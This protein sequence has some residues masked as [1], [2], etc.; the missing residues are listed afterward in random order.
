[1]NVSW[2]D[3]KLGIRMLARYPWLSAVSV[4]GMALAIAIGAGYVSIVDLALDSTLPVSGGDRIVSI[5][6]RAVDGPD[7]GRKERLSPQDFVQWRDGVTSLDELG[8]FRDETRN[9]MMADGRTDVVKVAAITASGFRLMHATALI[10]RTLLDEDERP[11]AAAVLVVGYDPWQRELNGDPRVV[12]TSV[13]LDGMAHTI[14]GVM[15]EGF[16]FP[17]RH[18]YWT[19][20]TI[21]TGGTIDEPRLLGF[22]RIADGFSLERVRA[23]LAAVGE[24]VSRASPQHRANVRLEPTPYTQTFTGI[25]GPQEILALRAFQLGAGLL[26]LIVA[27]N[28]AIL[29]YART[30]T[31]T[32]EVVVRTALGASRHRILLQFFVEAL[33]LTLA[34]AAVGLG[35]VAVVFERLRV[36]MRQA[37]HLDQIPYWFQPALSAWAVFYVVLLAVIAAVVVGVVPALKTTGRAVY[38][39]LQQFSARGSGMRLGRVWTTLIVVQVVSAV[40][41]LPIAMYNAQQVLALAT[42]TPAAAAKDMLRSTVLIAR[43]GTSSDAPESRADDATRLLQRIAAEPEVA[44]VTF[45]RNVPGREPYAT[46]D[47]E[48]T[49]QIVA[50]STAVATN[51]FDVFG[52]PILAGRGFVAADA[53][54]GAT[55]IVVDRAFADR[56]GAGANVVGRRIRY[57]NR[58]SN[59]NIELGRPLDIVGVV[60]VFATSFAAPPPFVSQPPRFYHAAAPDQIDGSTLIVRTKSND[61][62]Q[63]AQRLRLIAASV[64]PALK[65]QELVSVADAWDYD[66]HAPWIA[67]FVILGVTGSVLLLSGAGIYSMMS[68]AVAARRREIGIRVALGANARHV[69]SGIFG[70][71]IAQLGSGVAIGLSVA[72]G[73]EWASGGA[74]MNGHGVVLLPVVAGLMLIVGLLAALGPARHGLAIPPTE[75]LRAE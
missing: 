48:Q 6:S 3:V 53:R 65:L 36:W 31:R 64:D 75:A 11:G 57:L 45:A 32:G 13:R 16:L 37:P 46:V 50:S 26:L 34:S 9:L 1:M 18:Q 73:L 58:A 38:A 71:A 55:A 35:I 27:V 22:G 29:I 63:F 8:A 33:V 30:I 68:F 28:V 2:L 15:P 7:A 51:L 23:E 41:V 17:V 42:R 72:A 54:P 5:E 52:V 19:P 47:A 25:E 14:V 49:G 59:G 21:A 67:A 10:G 60:P 39:K 12:G 4:A 56:L 44:G 24:R 62:R 70:R 69:V 20:L 61:P 66:S 74:L 40:V 43:D